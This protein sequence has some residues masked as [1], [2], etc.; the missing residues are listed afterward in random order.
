M[1]LIEVIANVLEEYEQNFQQQQQESEVKSPDDLRGFVI[2]SIF[3]SNFFF[4]ISL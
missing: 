2:I 3:K 1:F 4:N